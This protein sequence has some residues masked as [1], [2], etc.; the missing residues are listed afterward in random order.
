MA[1]G[2]DAAGWLALRVPLS[3]CAHLRHKLVH[4][5]QSD[6]RRPA[7]IPGL[8]LRGCTFPPAALRNH[9]LLRARCQ[10]RSVKLT[11]SS[12]LPWSHLDDTS[13]QV[14]PEELVQKPARTIRRRSAR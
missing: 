3:R 8:D 11:Q 14:P 10:C 5:W 1:D 9:M 7:E 13:K 4:L 2:D 6:A 12:D